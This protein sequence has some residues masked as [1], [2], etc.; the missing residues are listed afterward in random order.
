MKKLLKGQLSQVIPKLIKNIYCNP[1]HIENMNVYIQNKKEPFVMVKND[2]GWILDSKKDV[3]HTLKE[4]GRYM[5]DDRTH[6]LQMTEKEQERSDKVLYLDDD[7]IDMNDV[8]IG[9]IN[10][11]QH[12]QKANMI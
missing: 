10:N 2:D 5:F 6:G 7:E 3:M 8:N 4:N 9:L 12:L 11:K 1:E